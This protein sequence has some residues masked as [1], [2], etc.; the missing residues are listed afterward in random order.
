MS[1]PKENP[2]APPPRS[3]FTCTLG[4][5][6]I[7]NTTFP[8]ALYNTI[9]GFLDFLAKEHPHDIAVGSSQPS[10]NDSGKD[11]KVEALSF[12]DLQ[13][14]SHTLSTHLASRLEG[15]TA[16]TTVA[17]YA[18]S[19][20]A[21]V[22]HLFAWL[23]LGCKVV[24][25][26]TAC[27]CNAVAHLLKACGATAVCYDEKHA[28]VVD[29]AL[30]V[31]EGGSVLRIELQ[32]DS[33]S[34]LRQL[35]AL[36]PH[37]SVSTVVQGAADVVLYGHS[38][39][40]STGLPKPIP[41]THQ[42]EIGALPRYNQMLGH[43]RPDSTFSTTPIY[44]GGLA[45]LWRSWSAGTALWT[46]AEN[47]V[48]ITAE[49]I[50]HYKAA[51]ETWIAEHQEHASPIG[52]VSCVPFVT[53]LM[54]EQSD[55]LEWLRN[56]HMVGVGGAAMPTVLGDVLVDKSVN[57]VSRF[58]SRECGFLLS[59]DRE[60]SNDREWQY[61]RHDNR[62]NSIVFKDWNGT[63]YELFVEQTWPSLSP[64]IRGKLPFNSHDIFI[65][66]RTIKNAWKYNGRSDVQITLTTGKKFDPAGIETALGVSEW[67][68]DAVVVGNDRSIPA[69]IV[70]TSTKAESLSESERHEKVFQ[71]ISEVN[72]GCPA[73]AR[74]RRNMV[75]ILPS[76]KASL[77]QK[78]SKGT[79]MRGKFAEDFVDTI[80]QLYSEDQEHLSGPMLD[81]LNEEE[82]IQ[83]ISAI[84]TNESGKVF[85]ETSPGFYEAGIDSIVSLQ[86]RN[87]IRA[88]LPI[89]LRGK[90]PLN[91]V[92]NTGNIQTLAILVQNLGHSHETNS[93]NKEEDSNKRRLEIDSFL[94]RIRT[95]G[96]SNC[97]NSAVLSEIGN[98]SKELLPANQVVLMTGAT[99]FLGAHLLIE[100]VSDRRIHKIV[101]LVRR[102]SKRQPKY[103]ARE[104]VIDAVSRR[105][106]KIPKECEGKISYIYTILDKPDLGLESDF[107]RHVMPQVTHFVHAAWAVNFSL[108]LEAFNTQLRGLL[109][110]YNHARCGTT[111]KQRTKF[112]FVSSTASVLEA[113]SP[114]S[115]TLS[116]R[117]ED[118]SDSGYGK[119]KWAAETLLAELA[120]HNQQPEVLILRVGQLTAD[121]STGAWNLREAWPLMLDAGSNEISG[122][123][124]KLVLPDLSEI[125]ANKLDWLPVDLAAKAVMELVFTDQ[126]QDPNYSPAV[127]HV[128]CNSA[129]LNT[130]ADVNSWLSVPGS[131]DSQAGIE[132]VKIEFIP[133]AQWLDSLEAEGELG[134]EHPALSL[135]P[136]WRN[137]WKH[138]TGPR[139]TRE[140]STVYAESKSE[141]LKKVNSSNGS[142]D[143]E[144]F[145]RMLRWLLSRRSAAD[146]VKL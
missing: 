45:D 1:S 127:F 44:T 89:D 75:A 24:L 10:S 135:I 97:Q 46:Y 115:E 102:N 67:I 25:V 104:R 57:L 62:V 99:G 100:L 121:S 32:Y 139:T 78:S 50:L 42:D 17:L 145:L 21:Y 11:W 111:Q 63:D 19:S 107:I 83:E 119:S 48:P 16:S 133:P 52:Y 84:V 141:T 3:Y 73:H 122:Q 82:L 40:T 108:P 18:S 26:S 137:G 146:H 60:H 110:L 85:G 113:S 90:V 51:T 69:A 33:L 92:Y 68:K 114:I 134:S 55:L 27:G 72:E 76:D 20:L 12:T 74:L 118:C 91:V 93:W 142:M 4:E 5:A 7:L 120:H 132:N 126:S 98:D 123:R 94:K 79:V 101:C 86:I 56:V 37:G 29:E 140:F 116:Q 124:G 88:R 144:A 96:E 106:L 87:Q 64:A 2:S 61:L 131:T 66:H 80:R 28:A 53:Q 105:G 36:V 47:E 95:E 31:V 109:S 143:R 129:S 128:L 43:Q 77:I 112:V 6:K 49:N 54:A 58:G 136:L 117:H 103:G 138:V 15:G 8:P 23:R 14:L 22:V 13:A 39:G 81:T 9:N 30:P 65:P 70:F 71:T 125:S 34:C 130:W 35:K 59:S 41:V 38:S